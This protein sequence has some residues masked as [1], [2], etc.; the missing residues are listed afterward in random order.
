[1]ALTNVHVQVFGRVQGVF[2]RD[3]TRKKANELGLNGWVRNCSDGSVEA[4]LSG[5]EIA[6]EHMVDWLHRGSPAAHVQRVVAEYHGSEP[7]PIGF[8]IVY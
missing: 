6:V 5:T 1:M 8:H 2:F 3:Y 7:E 4:L